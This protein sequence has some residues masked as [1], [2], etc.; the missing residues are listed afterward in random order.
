[1]KNSGHA[2][3]KDS[4][5]FRASDFYCASLRITHRAIVLSPSPSFRPKYIV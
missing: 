4:A 2:P 5:V 1:M 3:Q